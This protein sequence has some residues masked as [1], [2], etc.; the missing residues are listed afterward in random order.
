[1]A[2]KNVLFDW[3]VNRWFRSGVSKTD[4]KRIGKLVRDLKVKNATVEQ[5]EGCVR[6]FRSTWP[7][8]SDTPEAVFKHWDRLLADSE[9]VRTTM[10]GIDPAEVE[11]RRQQSEADRWYRTVPKDERGKIWKEVAAHVR[12]KHG[13]ERLKKM[14]TDRD[15][16]VRAMWFFAVGNLR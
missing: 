6:R 5:L 1:M 12:E 13:E 2:A 16:Q 15:W 11:L 9:P 10:P 4:G 7:K 3:I 14:R 8:M